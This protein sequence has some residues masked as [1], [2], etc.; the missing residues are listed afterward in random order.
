MIFKS[1]QLSDFDIIKSTQKTL[2]IEAEF[3]V[4]WGKMKQNKKIFLL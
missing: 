3:R 1:L 2:E 4:W